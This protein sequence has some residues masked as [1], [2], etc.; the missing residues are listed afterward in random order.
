MKRIWKLLPFDWEDKPPVTIREAHDLILQDRREGSEWQLETTIKYLRALLQLGLLVHMG[1][2][3]Y[4][5]VPIARGKEFPSH[6]ECFEAY[7][8]AY[9][10]L[11]NFKRRGGVQ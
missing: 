3:T 5:S 2:K 10:R 1:D 8:Q 11:A 6:D 4:K 9:R 7:M